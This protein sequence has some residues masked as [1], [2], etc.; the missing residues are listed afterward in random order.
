[1]AN[2]YARTAAEN[3]LLRFAPLRTSLAEQMREAQEVYGAAVKAGQVT[4]EGTKQAV[5]EA[6]P[7]LRQAYGTG[8]ATQRG[9]ATLLG[10]LLASLP[11]GG[12]TDQ[13]KAGQGAE[14]Q[15][16]LANLLRQ[17][18]AGESQ[19]TQR[20]VEAAAGAQF[21]AQQ[22]GTTLKA[23]LKK[24]FARRG[25]LAGEEGAAASTEAARLQ[26]EAEAAA[27][28]ERAEAAKEDAA[29]ARQERAFKHTKEEREAGER[30]TQGREEKR[31]G[32]QAARKAKEGPAGE[33]PQT[34][35]ETA[36]ARSQIEA[37]KHYANEMGFPHEAERGEAVQALTE[38]KP[39][40][41]MLVP[42]K[43]ADGTPILH[44]NGE[45][46]MAHVPIPKIPAY[47]PDV[48]MST[49]LDLIEYNG[50][51]TPSTHKRLLQ[52]GLHLGYP[53]ANTGE[54][55]TGRIRSVRGGAGPPARRR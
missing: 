13:Y 11:P 9:N 38:G 10:N 20:G 41:T 28:K 43:R 46:V 33:K 37:I 2:R 45:P 34:P 21:N 39:Q 30:G 23:E 4:A 55:Q 25:Q 53:V 32:R 3:A 16:Q 26:S 52:S 19:L 14:V 7:Q 27:R 42:A 54:I 50:H 15:Q 44:K 49:A 51:I 5:N 12:V 31:E 8:E 17:R 18:T 40:G 24:L 1:M 36:A 48:L 29:E 6:I 47:A 22:A 35:H